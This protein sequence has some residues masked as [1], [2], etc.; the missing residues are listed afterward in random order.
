ML[1]KIRNL[2]DQNADFSYLSNGEAAGVSTLRVKNINAFAQNQAIQIGKTGE[3]LAEVLVLTSSAPSGT[4]I[5]TTANTRYAHPTDVPVYNIKFDKVVFKKS[6][7]GT[8]GTAVPIVGGT[9]TI[10][11]DSL[12]TVYDDNTALSTDAFTVSLFNSVTGELSSDSDWITQTGRSFYSLQ[13]LKER[14][15][16]K[17]F[18]SAFIKDD[19]IITDW[20]NEWLEQMNNAAIKANE[21]YGVGTVNVAF[22]TSGLGTITAEDFVDVTKVVVTYNGTD[23]YLAGKK[24]DNTIFPQDEFNETHPYYS[25]MGDD[26]FKI[27]PSAVPGTAEITYA[28][29]Y[30][31]FANETDVIPVSMRTFSQSFVDYCISQAYYLDS[32]ESLGDRFNGKAEKAKIDFVNQITPRSYTGPQTIDIL[33]AIDGSDGNS[34]QIG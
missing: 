7:S 22:G 30:G 25:W 10:T 24:K 12:Y 21:S 27:R 34:I 5:T 15:K 1:L 32:K 8:A 26:V 28:S 29:I 3:E 14:V 23:K 20:L 18:S 9:V 19:S 33:D 31:R 13:R 11:P 16:S 2:L 4:S 6:A 17:L